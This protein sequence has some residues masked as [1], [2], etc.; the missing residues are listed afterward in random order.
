MRRANPARCPTCLRRPHR[1][2][3]APPTLEDVTRLAR[4]ITAGLERTIVIGH[5]AEAAVQLAQAARL[6]HS[7]NRAML[8]ARASA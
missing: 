5:L 7:D 1:P 3:A 2:E 4:T 8:S 6:Q